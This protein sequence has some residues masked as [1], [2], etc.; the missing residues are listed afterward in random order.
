MAL[1]D[2]PAAR[3]RAVKAVA[4]A[5]RLPLPQGEELVRVLSAMSRNE[6]WR[7]YQVSKHRAD[8]LLRA[9]ADGNLE[10]VA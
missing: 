7:T 8:Q 1:S 3:P 9:L 5:D 2:R 4:D 10:E 6:I